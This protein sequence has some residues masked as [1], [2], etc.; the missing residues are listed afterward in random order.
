MSNAKETPRPCPQDC[1]KCTFAQHA[2]CAAQMAFGLTVQMDALTEKIARI[3]DIIASL[4]AAG[5]ELSVPM[6]DEEAQKGSGA[7][8]DSQDKN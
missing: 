8:V 7:E 5:T 3:D 4:G 1:R 6:G 2:Y